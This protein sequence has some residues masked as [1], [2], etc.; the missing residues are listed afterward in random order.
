V[1]EITNPN[2]TILGIN[3]ARYNDMKSLLKFIL[4]FSVSLNL[5]G[6]DDRTEASPSSEKSKPISDWLSKIH[7]TPSQSYMK[8]K[9]SI[10]DIGIHTLQETGETWKTRL[11]KHAKS[12]WNTV[13]ECPGL[14]PTP[15]NSVID[16]LI[17]D[18]PS[19]LAEAAGEK[20]LSRFGTVRSIIHIPVTIAKPYMSDEDSS[21]NEK[22]KA[23]ALGAATITGA[24]IGAAYLNHN[25]I[26]FSEDLSIPIRVNGVKSFTLRL[27]G[28]NIGFK[29]KNPHFELGT[30][31]KFDNDASISIQ[32]GASRVISSGKSGKEKLGVAINF[33]V[34]D[35]IKSRQVISVRGGASASYKGPRSN[36]NFS[37]GKYAGAISYSYYPR[38]QASDNSDLS[39]IKIKLN[40]LPIE[41]SGD[42]LINP[43]TGKVD[44]KTASSS[45]NATLG[46]TLNTNSSA[47]SFR[48]GVHGGIAYHAQRDVTPVYGASFSIVVSPK[49]KSEKK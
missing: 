2:S 15:S 39:K 24:A 34:I 43:E 13:G 48:V 44:K 4:I 7:I 33:P 41:V 47:T 17:D 37:G 22:Q 40:I 49:M 16:A 25:E 1:H 5:L 20:A 14:N 8:T 28:E 42:T 29:S 31:F 46:Y 6:E 32:G 38:F 23:I 18:M 12:S 36:E 30:T 27:G 10:I 19:I 3:F 45:A 9:S 11:E 21:L 26:S 35:N